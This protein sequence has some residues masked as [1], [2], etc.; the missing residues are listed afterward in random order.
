MFL[1]YVTCIFSLVVF[2][3]LF[4]LC[5]FSVLTMIRCMDFSFLIL[6]ILYSVCFLYLY[7]CDGCVFPCLGDIFFYDLF[8]NP[9]YTIDL[10]FCLLL[11]PIIQKFGFLKCPVGSLYI[12]WVPFLWFF[13]FFTYLVYILYFIFKP[14]YSVFCLIHS[15]CKAFHWVF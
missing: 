1:L 4:L 10:G 3:M 5:I 6:S 2:N 13:M 14:W 12:L 9:F 8:G 11:I 15:N 7:G